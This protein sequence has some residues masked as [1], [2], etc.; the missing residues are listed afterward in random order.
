MEGCVTIS[1]NGPGLCAKDSAENLVVMLHGR[2]GSGDNM[3]VV[4]SQMSKDLPG[5]QFIAPHAYRGYGSG[6]A[7]FSDSVRDMEERTAL[8]EIMESVEIVNKFIDAQLEKF[9]MGDDKLSL[10]GFSQGAMLSIY[11]GL[12]RKKRC[13]S[14]VAYSGAVLF[15]NALAIKV[16]SKP[17]V[18]LAHGTSDDVVP[19]HYFNEGVSFLNTHS[20]PMVGHKMEG[21]NHTISSEG[22][23]LGI[24]FIKEHFA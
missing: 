5:T 8:I 18:F 3:M 7:W 9:G 22:L 23:A 10:V 11:I 16:R 12:C 6:Y 21:V 15:P 24:K 2:G 14:V 19:F 4:A 20:V 13:A 1:I 17:N